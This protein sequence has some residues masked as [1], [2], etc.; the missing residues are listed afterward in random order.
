MLASVHVALDGFAQSFRLNVQDPFAVVTPSVSHVG[1]Q[2]V[3][4]S[5]PPFVF[6][7]GTPE[8]PSR[9]SSIAARAETASKSVTTSSTSK[10]G[11]KPSGS[12]D[13]RSRSGAP[14][15]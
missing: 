15:K 10:G 2:S 12:C 1:S 14:G 6:A 4:G 3:Q 8:N 7:A 9:Q 5:M 13:T 11:A